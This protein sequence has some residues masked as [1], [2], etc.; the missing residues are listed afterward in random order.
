MVHTD[1]QENEAEGDQ[2]RAHCGRHG[3]TI[4]DDPAVVNFPVTRAAVGA[5]REERGGRREAVLGVT[6]SV[7]LSA[8][9]DTVARTL[10]K[11]SS[12]PIAELITI[13]RLVFGLYTSS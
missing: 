9:V 3:L 10:L 5:L 1:R 4:V 2:Y 12:E 6:V 7:Q 8:C 11:Q 13:E